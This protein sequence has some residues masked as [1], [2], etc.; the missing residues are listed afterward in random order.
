MEQTYQTFIRVLRSHLTGVPEQY[1]EDTDWN[2]VADLAAMHSVQAMAFQSLRSVEGVPGE[3]LGKLSA[4]YHATIFRDAQFDHIR[5]EIARQL[6]GVEHVFLR[7]IC[8]KR[9]YP[10]PALRTMSDIDILVHT[11]DYKSIH[12]AMTAIGG[13]LQSKDDN[14]RSYLFPG[15][16]VVEF[17]PNLN[18]RGSV[19]EGINPGWQYTC[20][21]EG[22]CERVLTEEGFYL[23]VACHLAH[24][25][26][27]GGTGVRSVMDLWVC[28]HLRKSQPDRAFVEKELS[29]FGLLE[30]IKNIE[31]LGDAWFSGGDM[32]DVLQEL[33]MYILTSGTYGTARRLLLSKAYLAGGK[34]ASAKKKLFPARDALEEEFPW[35]AGKG[36]LLPVAWAARLW[37]RATHANGMLLRRWGTENLNQSEVQIE[38]H[39]QRLRRFGLTREKE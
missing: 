35:C 13:K 23:N 21:G 12:T 6:A 15:K 39:G 34:W 20:P 3:V 27:S 24:H 38:A 11:K 17:H 28:R 19:G 18:H 9:D 2:G 1:P 4:A 14:Q 26:A 7:G 37:N 5:S 16:V 8:L 36:V 22:S 29:R 33:G 32:T 31:A 30:L 10:V 25:F